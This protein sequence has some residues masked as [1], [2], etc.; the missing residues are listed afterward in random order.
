MPLTLEEVGKLAG[1]SRS[2]VS[3]VVNGHPSVRDE[4]RE[5]VWQVIR[6]TGYQPHAAA[7]SLASRRSQVI[8]VIIPEAVS[9]LFVDP[10]FALLLRGITGACNTH[11]YQL[12]LSLFD[13][14]AD[15]GETYRR[16]LRSG[17]MDG[18]LVASTHM[19]DPIFPKLLQDSIP[20]VLVGRHPDPRVNYV[21]VDNVGGARMAVEHL[22]RLGHRRIATITGTLNM[23]SGEDRLAGYCQALEAHRIPVQ[24]ALIGEGDFTKSSGTMGMQRLLSA[25]PTAV[26]AASDVMAMGAL[27]ALREAS[28]RVPEDVALVGFD[29]IPVAAALEPALT[30]VRQPIDRLGSMAADLLLNLLENAPD[31]RAP[32]ARIIL[33]A[34]LI[35]RDSCGALH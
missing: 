13:E 9:T 15:Q 7:R 22:I 20:F 18:V 24:A 6:E 4:V 31:A 29:D 16:I 34:R 3:R 2:T 30:T 10:F 26:F 12:M 35:V 23:A 32:A 8:G 11:G 27:K 14:P 28:L 33:S 17:R 1:V 25:S 19:N 21:D 5:R